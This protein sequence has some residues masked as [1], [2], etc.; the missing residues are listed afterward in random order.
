M[1]Q[2]DIGV[3]DDSALAWSRRWDRCSRQDRLDMLVSL[4]DDCGEGKRAFTG[5]GACLRGGR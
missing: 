2:A 1:P 4:L 5:K 3:R